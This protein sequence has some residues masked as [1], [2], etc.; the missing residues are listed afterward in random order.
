MWE[1][2][3][4]LVMKVRVCTYFGRTVFHQSQ[5]LTS[6]FENFWIILLDSLKMT[7]KVGKNL[8]FPGCIKLGFL[9]LELWPLQKRKNLNENSSKIEKKSLDFL[10]FCVLLTFID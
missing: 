1:D 6:H 7:F 5:A 9:P 2:T 8:E 10:L 4:F 3:V